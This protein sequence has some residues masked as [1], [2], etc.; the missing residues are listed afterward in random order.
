MT[1]YLIGAGALTF[2]AFAYIFLF[3]YDP[4]AP[5]P[6]VAATT[7]DVMLPPSNPALTRDTPIADEVAV[8]Q[9]PAS[10]DED[11][12]LEEVAAKAREN[13]PS[14]VNDTLTM[15]DALFV[16]R[17]RIIEYTYVTTAT[18]PR[19]SARAMR[20]LI[21]AGAK[22]LCLEGRQM[23]EMGVTLRNSFEDGNGTLFQRVYLL[24]EDCQQF[25]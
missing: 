20:A 12:V 6:N 8:T 14:S 17:M 4:P 5:A 2:L 21:E 15:T 19:A 23:F 24:P 3:S 22:Q 9:D 13:L 25:Y 10:V 11:A 7:P 1:K 16:P 18:D